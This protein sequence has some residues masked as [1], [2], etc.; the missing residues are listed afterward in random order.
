MPRP[1]LKFERTAEILDAYERCVAAHAVLRRATEKGVRR[2]AATTV[3]EV[4]R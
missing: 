1:S 4:R 3:R 2:G